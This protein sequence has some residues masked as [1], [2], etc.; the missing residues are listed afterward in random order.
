M[1]LFNE[2]MSDDIFDTQNGGEIFLINRNLHSYIS[3]IPILA[4]SISFNFVTLGFIY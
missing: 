2:D 1:Y 3:K 4:N